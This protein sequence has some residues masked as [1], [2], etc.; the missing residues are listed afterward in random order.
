MRGLRSDISLKALLIVCVV[1]QVVMALPHHHHGGSTAMCV[2]PMH[3]INSENIDKNE[4]RHTSST[5]TLGHGHDETETCDFKLDKSQAPT[6]EQEM[7]TASILLYTFYITLQLNQ[8]L[9]EM[10]LYSENI[11]K[12]K[13]TIH[14]GATPLHTTYIPK[15]LPTRAP[16][17]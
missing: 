17:A 15:A 11:S 6:R 4:M 12:T 9:A 16:T 2:N 10:Y 14:K 1:M 8:H 5:T 7:E 3:C 13:I